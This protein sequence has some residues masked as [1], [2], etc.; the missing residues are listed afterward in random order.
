MTIRE[1]LSRAAARLGENGVENPSLDAELLMAKA[2]G[3][4]RAGLY[5]SLNETVHPGD[6][7]DFEGLLEKRCRR[8]P[9][10]YIIGEQEFMGLSFTVGEGVLIPRADTEVLVETILN[11]REN[12]KSILDLCTGSGAAAVSLAKNIPGS[13]VTAVDISAKAL[14]YAERNA[15]RHGVLDRIDFKKRDILNW[16]PRGNYELVVSNPPYIPRGELPHLQ[17]EVR[18]E[19]ERALDGGPKGLSFYYTLGDI[20]GRC[21]APGGVLAMEIGWDQGERVMGII[22]SKEIFHHIEIIKDY[23]HRD[24]VILCGGKKLGSGTHEG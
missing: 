24:R 19:P 23:A 20:A 2:L 12:F 8:Y 9:L 5:A 22:K 6:R 16:M 17:E 18:F 13:R 11:L 3:V 4:T 14:E 21:L 1:L 15:E 10:Q 7:A